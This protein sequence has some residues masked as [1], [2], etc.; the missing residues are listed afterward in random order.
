[1]TTNPLFSVYILKFTAS[2]YP[3]G[4]FKLFV[5]NNN[6]SNGNGYVSFYANILSARSPI[7]DRTFEQHEWSLEQH[8]RSIEQHEWSIEQ[9][10]WSIEQHE[11]SIEQY[12]GNVTCG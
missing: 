3:F 7:T 11:R 10:E 8:E 5:R 1:M 4:I 2:E 12:S 9:H 6:F